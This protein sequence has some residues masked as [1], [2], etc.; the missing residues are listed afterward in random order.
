MP[1]AGPTILVIDDEAPIRRLLRVSLTS[2]RYRFIEAETGQDGLAQAAVKNPDLIMLD[3]DLPDLDGIVVIERLREWATTPIIVVS[4]R[5]GERDKVRALDAGAN[6]FVTKPFHVGELLARV[7]VAL[8][9]AQ[10]TNRADARFAARD[11][12]VD[13]DRRQVV[14]RGK[15]VHLTPIEFRLLATLIKYA[16]RVMTH[17]QL[18]NEVRGPSSGD[19]TQYLRVY[20][21]QLRQKLELDSSH[22]EYLLTEPGVGYRLRLDD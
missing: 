8:R 18:L 21:A 7:R 12:T 9:C 15:D 3:L 10:G 1:P 2:G 20:M 13:F 5:V 17:A 14:M 11:L 19:Q 16:G 6:D 22:P 4:G